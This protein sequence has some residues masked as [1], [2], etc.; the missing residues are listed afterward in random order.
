MALLFACRSTRYAPTARVDAVEMTIT[1][2]LL[3]L[4]RKRSKL[5]RKTISFVSRLL[6][7][8]VIHATNS[9]PEFANHAT[10][11]KQLFLRKQLNATDLLKAFEVDRALLS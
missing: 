11:E 2:S 10:S 6:H 8:Y 4:R 9:K 3:C 7:F 1:N 5:E